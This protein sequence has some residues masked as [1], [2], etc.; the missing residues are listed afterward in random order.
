[1]SHETAPALKDFRQYWDGLSYEK[2]AILEGN[3]FNTSRVDA[4]LDFIRGELFS[5]GKQSEAADDVVRK[6]MLYLNNAEKNANYHKTQDGKSAITE[7][8]NLLNTAHEAHQ[9]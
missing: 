4:S 5:G 6:M 1:M 8:V 9:F 7:I 3:I 2:Q